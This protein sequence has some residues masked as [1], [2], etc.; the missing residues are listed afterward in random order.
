MS[1]ADDDYEDDRPRR[2]PRRD[3]D[4][5]DEYDDRPRRG[6][7]SG[8]GGGGGGMSVMLVV[9]IL[10]AVLFCCGVP[11]AIGLL[12][13]AVTKVR[14]AAARANDTNNFRKV[15][16]GFH[17]HNDA[18]LR[19]P[20]ADGDVSWRVHLL[21]YLE[22]APLYQQFDVNQP[23]DSEKNRRHADVRVPP[24]VSALDPPEFAQTRARVFT[25]P[26]TLFPPGDDPLG[27][28]QVK[29]GSSST[30]LA[31]E[32]AEPVPWPQ[33]RELA[34]TKGGPLPPPGH[35]G[36]SAGVLAAMA[37]GSVRFIPKGTNDNAIRSAVTPAAGD[38][39][40][41]F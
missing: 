34:Y 27:L 19:F 18:K 24:Y 13:P 41:D 2:R 35:P 4:Y 22:Q 11:V 17:S 33:P 7:A 3:D 16:I 30:F 9:G 15:A 39:P 5:D 32:A 21:P 37:D 14:E 40:P 8:G 28:R 23:W 26:G 20:P 36:R 25:G 38:T 1:R 31:V 12:L 29:D 6:K 10:V